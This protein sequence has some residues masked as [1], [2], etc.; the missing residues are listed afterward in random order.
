MVKV[1]HIHNVSK[2]ETLLAHSIPF[3]VLPT[4]DVR[5]KYGYKSNLY[6]FPW[7]VALMEESTE[8]TSLDTSG[9]L[10]KNRKGRMGLFYTILCKVGLTHY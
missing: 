1:V 10:S 5:V 9:E 7:G 2:E 6:M 8:D 4:S 3:L